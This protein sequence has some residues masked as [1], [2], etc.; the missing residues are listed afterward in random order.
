MVR[1]EPLSVIKVVG[2]I[3]RF[4]IGFQARR[5]VRRQQVALSFRDIERYAHMGDTHVLAQ[6]IRHAELS[7]YI[8]KLREG[9]FDTNAGRESRPAIFTLRWADSSP[10]FATSAKIPAADSN[11]NRCENPSDIEM[12][13]LTK[14]IDKQQQTSAENHPTSELL[15]EEGFTEEAART[16]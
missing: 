3:I 4:S 2:S 7:H 11:E 13:S 12:K 14:E 10:F 8:L 16:L 15:R 1:N 9:V 6:A 5:G